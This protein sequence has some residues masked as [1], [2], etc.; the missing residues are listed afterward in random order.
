MLLL[1]NRCEIVNEPVDQFSGALT[2]CGIG[3]V[4]GVISPRTVTRT[5]IAV[6]RSMDVRTGQ[7]VLYLDSCMFRMRALAAHAEASESVYGLHGSVPP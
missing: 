6:H 3:S 2:P 4:D 7:S 5:S 1:L